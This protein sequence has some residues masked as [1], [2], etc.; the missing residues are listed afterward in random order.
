MIGRHRLVVAAVAV[1][2]GACGS[3]PAERAAVISSPTT[4]SHAEL[5][6]VVTAA[7][8]GAPVT[9]AAD[10]LTREPVLVVGHREPPSLAGR[11]AT[12]R[13]LDAAERFRLVLGDGRC[14]L[15]RDSD[16]RRFRLHDVECVPFGGAR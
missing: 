7:L 4:G 12:G 16:G 5:T 2:A 15:I 11:V 10:A 9:L 6:R 14:E 1:G 3:L 13:T 8:G